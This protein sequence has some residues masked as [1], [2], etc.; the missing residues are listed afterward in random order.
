MTFGI[1]WTRTAVKSLTSLDNDVQLRVV[2]RLDELASIDDP[3]AQ[4]NR[5]VGV[6]L[7]SLRIGD[8]RAILSIERNK[9]IIFVVEVGHRSKIYK[10]L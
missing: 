9:M 4:L 8:Y 2:K 1:R 10:K 6:K 5:L 7:Y 3:F